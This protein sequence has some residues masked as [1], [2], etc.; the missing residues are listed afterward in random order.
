VLRASTYGLAKGFTLIELMIA[1]AIIGLLA[2]VALPAYNSYS[3]RAKVSEAILALSACRSSVTE[4]YQAGGGAPSAGSWGCEANNMSR[5]VESITTDGNGAAT[6]TLR[7]IGSG[8]DGKVVTL[9]PLI[10]GVPADAASDMGRG[11]NGWSCGG[12]G[13][14]LPANYLPASCR[15]S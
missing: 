15:G 5:Y 8:I 12:T 1:V 4:I 11:I 6:A 14:D 2:S 3:A 9:V 13:T 7:N 10:D